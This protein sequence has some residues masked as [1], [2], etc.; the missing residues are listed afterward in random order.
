MSA[1]L[2]AFFAGFLEA[3]LSVFQKSPEERAG[4]AETTAKQ[5]AETLKIVEK[6][7]EVDRDT[8]HLTDSALRVRTRQWQRPDS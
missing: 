1:I 4:I 8:A 3:F 2:K 5:Q 7:N 6:A